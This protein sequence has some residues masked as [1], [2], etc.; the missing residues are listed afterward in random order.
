ME[1]EQ[2]RE[3][4]SRLVTPRK[5]CGVWCIIATILFLATAGVV[6]VSTRA[7]THGHGCHIKRSEIYSPKVS[8]RV[9]IALE[10]AG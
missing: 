3:E 10:L 1:R 7:P 6:Y 4:I 9:E 8:A 2:L 5:V